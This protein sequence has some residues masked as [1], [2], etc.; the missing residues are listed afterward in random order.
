MTTWH[1]GQVFDAHGYADFFVRFSANWDDPGWVIELL[2]DGNSPLEH[3]N[4]LLPSGK[5][6]SIPCSAYCLIDFRAP[7]TN[8]LPQQQLPN[9]FYVSFSEDFS[10]AWVLTPNGSRDKLQLAP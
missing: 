7:G 10:H 9:F 4:R 2:R 6:A 1:A 3:A 8:Q 5:Y